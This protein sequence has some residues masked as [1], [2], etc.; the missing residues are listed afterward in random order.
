MVVKGAELA[1]DYGLRLSD[2]SHLRR[3]EFSRTQVES[4]LL[5]NLFWVWRDVVEVNV[6]EIERADAKGSQRRRV[7]FVP[8]SS[9]P[10]AGMRLRILAHGTRNKDTLGNQHFRIDRLHCSDNALVI[11]AIALVH[12]R[13]PLTSLGEVVSLVIGRLE[14]P[15]FLRERP[16]VGTQVCFV[17]TL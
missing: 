12:Q 11:V 17:L 4:E 6:E 1:H 14:R 15:S 10:H 9:G 7:P 3:E 13:L 16:L 2:F 5:G 8:G